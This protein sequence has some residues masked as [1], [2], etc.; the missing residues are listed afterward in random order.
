[1][2]QRCLT[3]CPDCHGTGSDPTR[4]PDLP[5]PEEGAAMICQRCNGTGRLWETVPRGTPHRPTEP[6]P[7]TRYHS[8]HMLA[9]AMRGGTPARPRP[10]AI[11]E[12]P[13]PWSIP[14]SG[15]LPLGRR[16]PSGH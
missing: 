9:E 11:G 5:R 14:P 16:S 13:C 4:R 15:A 6:V 3:S 8:P 1:M 10:L 12:E 2:N 7:P